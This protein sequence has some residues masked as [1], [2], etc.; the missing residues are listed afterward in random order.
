M[1]LINFKNKFNFI[2]NIDNYSLPS[3]VVSLSIKSNG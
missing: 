2:I 1:K 3:S